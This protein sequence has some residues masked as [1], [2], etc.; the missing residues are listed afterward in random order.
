MLAGHELW[1]QQ[2]DPTRRKPQV[3][4]TMRKGYN[5]AAIVIVVAAAI[6]VVFAA[7]VV[8][9]VFCHCVLSPVLAAP[10]IALPALCIANGQLI[11]PWACAHRPSNILNI[12][13]AAA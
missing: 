11:L 12:S 13:R 3:K 7:F 9:A 8:A 1:Q 6:V 5:I 4:Q 2:Q 10:L